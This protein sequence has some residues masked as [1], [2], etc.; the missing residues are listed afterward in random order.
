VDETRVIPRPYVFDALQSDSSK[1]DPQEVF[2][3][4]CFDALFYYWDRAE[5][6]VVSGLIRFE[7]AERPTSYYVSQMTKHKGIYIRYAE[8]IGSIG[9]LAF[10]DRFE[11]WR[12]A[13][14]DRAV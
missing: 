14:L 12:V 1:N 4:D 9:A 3:Q 13:P 7:D 8:G 11:S 6:F 10:L 2:I 5:Q